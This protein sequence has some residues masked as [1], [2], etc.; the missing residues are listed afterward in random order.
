MNIF[1][2][3]HWVRPSNGFADLIDNGLTILALLIPSDPRYTLA[4]NN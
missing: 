2:I 4:R 1:L 3:K